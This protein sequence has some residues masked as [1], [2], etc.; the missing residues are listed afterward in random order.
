MNL[1]CY[2][3]LSRIFLI[4]PIIY[5]ISSGNQYLAL[6]LFLLAGFTDY[7][8]GFIARRTKTESSLGAL[9]DLLA[10]KLLVCLVLLWCAVISES[11]LIVV[12]TFIII[13]RELTISSLRQFLVEKIGQNPIKVSYVAK[14]KTTVQFISISFL[15]LSLEKG[16]FLINIAIFLLWIAALLSVYSLIN[17]FKIYKDYL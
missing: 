2:V 7:L 8:D 9:L 6:S 17:Y 3:T 16:D 5:F 1:A 10:D 14:S 13:C 4:I 12:A 15:I 11:L